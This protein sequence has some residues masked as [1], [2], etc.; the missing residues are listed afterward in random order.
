MRGSI[1]SGMMAVVSASCMGGVLVGEVSLAVG[2]ACMA[3][4]AEVGEDEGR[5]GGWSLE[6]PG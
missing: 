2:G 1:T 4:E 5:N 3:V 6:L